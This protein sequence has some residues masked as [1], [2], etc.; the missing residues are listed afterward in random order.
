[1]A[2]KCFSVLHHSVILNAIQ[3][4]SEAMQ[5]HFGTHAFE[6]QVSFLAL[7]LLFKMASNSF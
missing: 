3:Y 6:Y 7:V 4:F 2:K 1:M 5:D